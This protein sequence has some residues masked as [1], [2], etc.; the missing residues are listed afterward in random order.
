MYFVFCWQDYLRWRWRR[1]QIAAGFHPPNAGS[2]AQIAE[3]FARTAE[4]SAVMYARLGK[5]AMRQGLTCVSIVRIG[6]KELRSRNFARTGEKSDPIDVKYLVTVESFDR[7]VV[8]YVA[9]DAIFGTIVVTRDTRGNGKR[10][11]GQF[12]FSPFPG[13]PFLFV[14]PS[15]LMAGA[16]EVIVIP[17]ITSRRQARPGLSSF[18]DCPSVWYQIWQFVHSPFQQKSP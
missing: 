18:V 15:S 8:I 6:A 11:R 3:R 5:I 16:I 2:C 14:M 9:T 1:I 12:S 13:Y 4:T 17:S 7:T 10:R